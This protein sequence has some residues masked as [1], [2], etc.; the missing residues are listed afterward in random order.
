MSMTHTI[1][2]VDT[3][4]GKASV[5]NWECSENTPL[6]QFFRELT[7]GGDRHFASSEGMW[8]KVCRLDS[9][10]T[11]ALEFGEPAG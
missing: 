6:G 9:G 7:R 1:M 3:E 5:L 8:V 10:K 2:A 4:K 11:F